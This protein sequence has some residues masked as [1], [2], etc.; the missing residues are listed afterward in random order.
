MSYRYRKISQRLIKQFLDK[1]N[2]EEKYPKLVSSQKELL[3]ALVKGGTLKEI[4]ENFGCTRDNIKK[5]T[6]KLYKKFEVN[7]RKSLVEK[8]IKF[9]FLKYSNVS[10]RF[11]KRFFYNKKIE[12]KKLI[13]PTV[14]ENLTEIEI[15]I[16][17]LAAEG[18]TKKKIADLLNFS[19]MHTCNYY[20]NEI[21]RKLQTNH[22]TCALIIAIKLGIITV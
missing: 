18:F 12:F 19:N 4:A 5:R 16:L 13:I 11:R 17:E 2:E 22:I 9:G 1:K 7:S 15:A 3:Y 10:F 8:A 20:Y 6:Q 14:S 21:Y